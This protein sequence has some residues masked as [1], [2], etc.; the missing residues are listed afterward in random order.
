MPLNPNVAAVPDN[1]RIVKRAAAISPRRR[2]LAFVA[3]G[4]APTRSPP[5]HRATFSRSPSQSPQHGPSQDGGSRPVPAYGPYNHLTGALGLEVQLAWTMGKEALRVVCI[6]SVS[7]LE[8]E[9][10]AWPSEAE[11]LDAIGSSL[12]Y[13]RLPS[14]LSSKVKYP[15]VCL[16]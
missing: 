1:V 7:A 13:T 11:L 14:S 2:R 9:E 10:G 5:R 16:R 15:G 8:A 3:D 4:H 6:A 12:G